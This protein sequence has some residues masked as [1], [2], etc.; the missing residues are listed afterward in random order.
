MPRAHEEDEFAA[1]STR[2]A[3]PEARRLINEV[4]DEVT[5][6]ELRRGERINR[7]RVRA[8]AFRT[9]LE[10]LIGD[11]LRARADPSSTGRIYRAMGARNFTD[12][13]VSYWNF[14][15]AVHALGGL[16]LLEHTP[17]RPR[18]IAAFGGAVKLTGQ[19]PRFR[20]TRTLIR[21][22]ADAGVDLS[23]VDR[24]F[25]LEPPRHPSVLKAAKVG[26]ARKTAGVR[27][28]S[29]RPSRWKAR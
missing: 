11:L 3:S 28:T 12:D 22:A 20:G 23:E 25:A 27:R 7:R 24:H 8:T 21:R 2:A 17:R 19:A 18:Y 26:S 16:K 29:P 14:N 4:F 10:R 13:V 9:T 1:L 5:T 6:W 15:A